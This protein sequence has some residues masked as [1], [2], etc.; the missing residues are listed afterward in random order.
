MHIRIRE[1]FKLPTL[2]LVEIGLFEQRSSMNGSRYISINYPRER[3]P[4]APCKSF[5]CEHLIVRAI[6]SSRGADCRR[7]RSTVTKCHSDNPSQLLLSFDG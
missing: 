5:Y 6:R 1:E 3:N 7:P 2:H 4:C